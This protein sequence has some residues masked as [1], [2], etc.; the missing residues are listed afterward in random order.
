MRKQ[1][2]SLYLNKQ[3]VSKKSGKTPLFFKHEIHGK[4]VKFQLNIKVNPEY[5]NQ[6]LQQVESDTTLTQKITQIRE[7]WK[8]LFHIGKN[9]NRSIEMFQQMFR[10]KINGEVR[11]KPIDLKANFTF[12][13][14]FDKYMEQYKNRYAHT[15]LKKFLTVKNSLHSYY[16]KLAYQE[17][18]TELF[19]NYRDKLVKR[20]LT[21]NYIKDL[22][23]IIKKACKFGR[24]LNIAIPM[25]IEEFR[26]ETYKG[27]IIWL[28]QEELT[29]LENVECSESE[30]VIKD[31]FLF[32]CYTGLRHSDM[33]HV[34]ILNLKGNRLEF[35]IQKQGKLHGITLSEGTKSLALLKKYKSFPITTGQ[36]ENRKLKIFCQRARINDVIETYKRSG[37]QFLTEAS[38]KYRKISGH[39]ARRTFARLAY[40]KGVEL[41][42][43]SK[44][45]GHSS[46]DVTL[47]YIGITLADQ[48]NI[49]F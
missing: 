18:T 14:L 19:D 2:P 10:E 20:Q 25:D 1:L 47:G 3:R 6:A 15:H 22:F 16:P 32:R 48:E 39:T 26:V 33:K 17:L 28:T 31:C 21:N 23:K 37:S 27:K 7:L 43:L 12:Y 9:D 44:F 13:E 35:N 45:L 30:Q 5:W 24:S 29:A 11:K 8:L 34:D 36:N 40:E 49:A 41:L 38:P 42:K 4:I 46:L